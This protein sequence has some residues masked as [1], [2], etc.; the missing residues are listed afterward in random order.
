MPTMLAEHKDIVVALEDLIK[1]AKKENKPNIVQFAKKL[2]LHAQMEER[3]MYPAALLIG[4]H[5]KTKRGASGSSP[6]IG[7]SV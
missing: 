4:L 2:M 1:A 7:V 5:V 6:T 3:V